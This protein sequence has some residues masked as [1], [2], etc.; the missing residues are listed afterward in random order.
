MKNMPP[1]TKI[2]T[3]FF[4]DYAVEMRGLW[5]VE[6]D[7]M[8]GPFV[9]YTFVDWRKNQIVT[10]FGYVYQPNKAK[11]NLLRQVEAI[12]YSTRFYDKKQ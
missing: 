5:R 7:F 12:I 1:Q 6:H 3:D 4:T 11:R 8:G 9:S 2:V 10:V